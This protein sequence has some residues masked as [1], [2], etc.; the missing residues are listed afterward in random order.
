MKDANIQGRSQ[1][2]VQS[3]KFHPSSQILMTA[4]LDKTVRLF[5]VDGK[6]NEL[7]QKMHFEN[8]PIY[9]SVF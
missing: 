2:V 4:G 9:S 3:L 7:I 1:A 6:D 8:F 5:N